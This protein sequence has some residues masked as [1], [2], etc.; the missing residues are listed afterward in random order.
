MLPQRNFENYD[1][2][3]VNSGLFFMFYRTSKR[4]KNVFQACP[5][6]RPPG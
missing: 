1:S 2:M 3:S 5:P 4:E 6:W